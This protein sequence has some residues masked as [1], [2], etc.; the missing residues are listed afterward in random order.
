M[1]VFGF[2]LMDF[3]QNLCMLICTIMNCCHFVL[4]TDL[5]SQ[6]SNVL[7]R[8]PVFHK[9][10]AQCPPLPLQNLSEGTVSEPDGAVVPHST[11]Y[12]T[13]LRNKY[14]PL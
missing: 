14:T 8:L 10:G 3:A 2:Q 4:P 11:R 6:G 7:L 13:T 9:E 12:I 5:E 1:I